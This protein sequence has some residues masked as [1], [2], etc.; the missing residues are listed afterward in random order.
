MSVCSVQTH[1]LDERVNVGLHRVHIR[2]D[3]TRVVI[4]ARETRILF[5]ELWAD[6]IFVVEC[7]CAGAAAAIVER[8]MGELRKVH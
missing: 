2:V 7:Q 6:G 5:G 3:I 1:V 4:C 8:E